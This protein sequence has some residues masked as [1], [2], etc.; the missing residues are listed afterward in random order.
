MG[1]VLIVGGLLGWGVRWVRLRSTAL[2]TIR[3]AGGSVSFADDRLAGPTWQGW[4][5]R[6][7]GIDLGHPVSSVFLRSTVVTRDAVFT[8]TGQLGSIE[9]L[10]VNGGDVTPANLADLAHAQIG[11]LGLR[12]VAEV[13]DAHLAAVARIPGLTGIRINY[14]QTPAAA[15]IVRAVALMTRLQDVD[16]HGCGPLAG[17][18]LIPLVRLPHL[19]RL[20]ITPAPVDDGY[21]ADLTPS[22]SLT[23]ME[24]WGTQ[25]TDDRLRRLAATH[26]NLV[27]VSFGGRLVT[28]AGVEAVAALPNLDLLSLLGDPSPTACLTDAS[29]ITLGRSLSLR[30]L[31]L[32]GGRFTDAG[33]DV[34]AGGSLT[35]LTLGSIES[36]SAASLARLVAGRRFG[37]LELGGPA[38]TDAV[39]SLIVGNLDPRAVLDL[40]H[41]AVTDAGMIHLVPVSLAG[42]DLTGTALTDAG[43]S[44][45]AGIK[46]VH[47][48]VVRETRVTP[49]GAAAFRA[50]RPGSRLYLNLAPSD[51]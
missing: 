45:L 18:D 41:S 28:D 39:L 1:L 31:W 20:G 21:L 38:I 34:L 29:L 8:A 48:L 42:L 5:D 17:A 47:E 40:S 25:I 36:A 4:L 10:D 16:I 3:A 12:G 9:Y 49:A 7:T 23:T 32:P 30:Q 6:L 24:L 2:A 43:L 46:M 26:P 22:R 19:Q 33:L 27:N 50:A 11:S 15:A 35:D 51:D 14:P 37:R 44:T 13:T